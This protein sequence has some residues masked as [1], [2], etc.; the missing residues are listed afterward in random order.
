MN[1]LQG[2]NLTE[3][4]ETLHMD[5]TIQN[6]PDTRFGGHQW[7][8]IPGRGVGGGSYGTSRLIELLSTTLVS[9]FQPCKIV[10]LGPIEWPPGAPKSHRNP[11]LYM[12]SKRANN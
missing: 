7:S 6:N 8:T 5:Q 2:P 11:T 12:E 10:G 1:G 3:L 9:R 4:C